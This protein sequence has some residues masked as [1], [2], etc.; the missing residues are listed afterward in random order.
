MK[1][2]GDGINQTRGV[3]VGHGKS[4]RGEGASVK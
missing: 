3:A 1:A 4:G 2:L